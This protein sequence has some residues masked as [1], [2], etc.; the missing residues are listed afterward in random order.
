[1]LNL[2]DDERHISPLI[3]PQYIQTF[4]NARHMARCRHTLGQLAAADE[5]RHGVLDGRRLYHAQRQHRRTLV[6]VLVHG[7]SAAWRL[8]HAQACLLPLHGELAFPALPCGLLQ[9]Y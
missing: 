8:R 9:L 4:L 1:M 2:A 7:R 6:P 3:S 5:R